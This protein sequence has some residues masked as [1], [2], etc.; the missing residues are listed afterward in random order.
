MAL[1]NAKVLVVGAGGLGC[2]SITYLAAAG[3][4][5]I[6]V[7]DPDIVE[8]SNLARQF[9]HTD[10][11]ATQA[12]A[13]ATS[14]AEAASK[15]NPHITI[16]PVFDSFTA[17]NAL[18][19]V[20]DADLVLDCTDNPLTRYLI[21]DAAVL[22]GKPIISGAAQGVEGQIVVLNKPLDDLPN[23]TNRGPCYR[24]LF[25]TAP[26]PEDVQNCSDGGVLGVI[27]GLVGTL[28]ALEAIKLLARLGED[29]F[30]PPTLL[31]VSP[32]SVSTPAF[33][34]IKLRPRRITTCRVCGDPAQLP[35]TTKRVQ[36]LEEEDYLSFCGLKRVDFQTIRTEVA[37]IDVTS[38]AAISNER[39]GEHVPDALSGSDSKAS[40]HTAILPLGRSKATS[41]GN[42]EQ[43]RRVVIDV[44]P[45]HE[46]QI[47]HLAPSSNI[48]LAKLR[49]ALN[50][51]RT[52][53]TSR[54]NPPNLTAAAEASTPAVNIP[55][56]KAT[57]SFWS[58]LDI[59]ASG[60]VHVLCRRGNDSQEAVTILNELFDLAQQHESL[61]PGHIADTSDPAGIPGA[62]PA[63]FNVR[64]G[65]HAYA[66][67]VDPSFPV[68]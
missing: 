2:P 58:D 36:S 19:L 4:G 60:Q 16:V 3:V 53:K 62:R 64:G 57:P 44:R 14:A 56:S 32:L 17:S 50:S 23:T 66:K 43:T 55:A 37:Q 28:Q 63:I 21:N 33:R 15:I 47:A 59:P 18:S 1:K 35:Q 67:D 49:K 65:L 39:P 27:T 34:T 30:A 42:A 40:V 7:I 38:F 31:L 24:C 25:P 52:A 10:E 54:Q 20:S 45:P 6:T 26:R 9:L 11:G 61:A 13:K 5:H 51:R 29:P 41:H 46:Y 48:P 22:A 68:Y 12:K 8:T